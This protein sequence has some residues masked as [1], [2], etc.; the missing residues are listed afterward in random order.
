MMNNA[1]INNEID[2]AY[3][4]G[5]RPMSE[6]EMTR[7][8]GSP[9]NRWGV[10]DPDKHIIL[11]VSWTK[12]GFLQTFTDAESVLIGIESRLCRNLLNYQKVTS[13]KQKLGKQKAEAIRFEYRVND[14]RIVQVGDVVV[15]KYKKKFY[16]IHYIIRKA[17]ATRDL[18]V[19]KEVLDSV[20]FG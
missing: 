1:K 19:F 13:Y 17:T 4:D 6:E 18:P 7:Y 16:V 5:F 15:V 20:S 3:P 10:Y 8:F 9:E 11:S 2:L 12:A 14:A